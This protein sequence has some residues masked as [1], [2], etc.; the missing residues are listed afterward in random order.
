VTVFRLAG[1]R[2]RLGIEAPK[3]ISILRSELRQWPMA[4]VSTTA[5][6]RSGDIAGP[7]PCTARAAG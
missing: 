5:D 6:V 4:P 1:G 2:V 7:S 3:D